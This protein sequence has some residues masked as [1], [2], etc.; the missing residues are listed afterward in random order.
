MADWLEPALAYARSWLAF[1]HRQHGLPG[2]QA[3][4]R[5]KG[6]VVLDLAVGKASLATGEDLTPRHRLRVASHSKTFTAVG[7]MKL[8]DEGRLRLDDRAGAYVKKLHPETAVATV[9]Q[10]L[11]HSAGIIRDGTDAGQWQ[12][13]RPFL[14]KK[15][16]KAALAEAPLIAVNSRFKYSN[17]GYGLLGLI[18]EKV[19]GEAY[20]DWMAREV[21]AAAGLKETLP[22][23]PVPK[24]VALADG[25]GT[26]TLLG[27][28]FVVPMNQGTAALAAATGFVST[29]KDLTKLVAQLDPAASKSILSVASRREMVRRH[30]KV[31]DTGLD[32]HYGLGTMHG[33]TGDWAWYGHGGVFPGCFSQTCVLPALGLTISVIVNA[34]DVVPATLVDGVIEILRQFRTRGAPAGHLAGW[35]G[36]WWSMWGAIDLL[37]IGDRV[38]AAVPGQLNPFFDASEIVDVKGN[39]AVVGK[40]PGIANYREAVRFETDKRGK[41]VA[42]WLG[43]IRLVPEDVAAAELRKAYPLPLKQ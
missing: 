22:D 37:P 33:G 4:V 34:P 14:D 41:P 15:E 19:T 13:R 18:L 25:H 35:T 3:A 7:I 24:G 31:P 27:E 32:R 21:V 11:S 5:H 16:L 20:T 1:Q 28:R 30:W 43:G 36:R 40:A 2:L 10:L 12:G 39:D 42:L 9:G 8:V 6:K 26:R 29:A 23:A 17:H 38:V